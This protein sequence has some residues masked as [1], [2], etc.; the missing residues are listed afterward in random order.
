MSYVRWSS[1]VRTGCETCGDTDR[2]GD[3]LC[4]AC[5]SCWYIYWS[6][7]DF[8][9]LHHAC[10]GSS[11]DLSFDDADAW[12]PPAS[13]PMGDVALRAVREAV[14]DWR[15]RPGRLFEVPLPKAPR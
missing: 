5:T 7:G 9:A 10:D 1:K 15:S 12:T 2:V 8:I 13:C 3:H 6:V 11:E 4:R 14:E